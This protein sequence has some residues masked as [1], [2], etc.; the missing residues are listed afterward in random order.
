M[1][2][3]IATGT[4]SAQAAPIAGSKCP[5]AGATLTVDAKRY[6]CKKVGKKLKWRAVVVPQ[7]KPTP[8]SPAPASPSASP[9]SYL[10]YLTVDI[11]PV[12]NLSVAWRQD[13]LV[14]AFEFDPTTGDNSYATGFIIELTHED[15]TDRTRSGQFP[16]TPGIKTHRLE[17]PRDK[18]IVTT[19]GFY[20]AYRSVCVIAIGSRSAALGKPMCGVP[21][22][23]TF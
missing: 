23:W 2:A 7:P 11:G 4:S 1:L 13:T 9:K 3:L 16:I 10:D 15:G 14:F 8:V 12:S 19:G 17:L 20:T 22:K 6:I 21:G 5:K 18:I